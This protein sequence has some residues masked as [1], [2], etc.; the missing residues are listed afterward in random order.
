VAIGTN[1]GYSDQAQFSVAIGSN[2]GYYQQSAESIAIG[3]NAG[4]TS[5]LFNSVAI[6]HKSG[7]I[8]QNLDA[9]SIGYQAGQTSQG[10]RSIAIGKNA[11][12]GAY[13]LGNSI[14]L[15]ATNSVLSSPQSYSVC[16]KPIR[17]TTSTTCNNLVFDTVTNQ[18]VYQS[19]KSF[20]IPHPLD[21]SKYLVHGCVEGPEAGVYYRGITDISNG[22]CEVELPPYVSEIA[23][24]YSIFL[25]P[26]YNGLDH[27]VLSKSKVENGKFKVY[28]NLKSSTKFNWVV[29][30]TMTK[31]E[32][33]INRDKE[34]K[35]D[36]PYTYVF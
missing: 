13:F 36:G 28:S 31:I 22:Y 24:N 26:I 1:A 7:E 15:N 5:Q 4:Y 11:G 32:V 10:A 6:G 12:D 27:H 30:A 21:N 16:I 18:V 35:G 29:H 2:A 23:N 34:I 14:I 8:A 17:E 19:T 3:T 9:I 33:E 25:T 20:V